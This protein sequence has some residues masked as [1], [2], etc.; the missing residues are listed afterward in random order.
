MPYALLLFQRVTSDQRPAKNLLWTSHSWLGKLGL[1]R[2]Q[3]NQSHLMIETRQVLDLVGDGP[4]YANLFG[5][6]QQYF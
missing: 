6:F 5:D 4:C 2:T 3:N 1:L